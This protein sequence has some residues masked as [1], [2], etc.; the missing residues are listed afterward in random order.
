[1]NM[2][3]FKRCIAV[4]LLLLGS[5]FPGQ[6]AFCAITVVAT[7]SEGTGGT[8]L[9]TSGIDTTGANLIVI[10]VTCYSGGGNPEL[11]SD[12]YGNT[13]TGLSQYGNG[14]GGG[15]ALSRLF[16]CANPVVGTGHTFTSNSFQCTVSIVAVSGAASS[17]FDAETGGSIATGTSGQPGSITPSEGN[18]LVV[19]GIGLDGGVSYSCDGGYTAVT[20][21]SGFFSGPKGGGL[22]YIVQTTAMA[23]NPTWSWSNNPGD[24]NGGAGIAVFKSAGGGGGPPPPLNL[25]TNLVAAY[26]FNSTGNDLTANANNL[27]NNNSATFVAGKPTYATALALASSQYWS[28]ADNASLSMGDIDFTICAWVK[29]AAIATA[30]NYPGIVSKHDGG[31]SES[32]YVMYYNGDNDRM[33]WQVSS[34]G[35]DSTLVLWTSAASTGTWYWVVVDHD[36]THNRISISVNNGTPQTQS[37]SAGVFDGARPLE[38]GRTN[39]GSFGGQI[40]G[41]VGQVLIYKNRLLTSPERAAIYNSGS[42]LPYSSFAPASS[43]MFFGSACSRLRFTNDYALAP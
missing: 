22:A 41:E 11:N 25:K 20:T 40:D 16:Y 39:S 34:N 17:P 6:L 23:T 32:E 7:Q 12:T 5:L 33:A 36:A 10:E 13:W 31:A 26:E 15:T 4:G 24:N 30:G 18:C 21:N 38:I 37:T 27:T 29:F 28:I 35:S 14:L 19:T 3:L 2:K 1:M 9:T 8:G 43:R 42:G